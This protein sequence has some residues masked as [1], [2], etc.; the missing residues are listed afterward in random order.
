MEH[1]TWAPTRK[2][3]RKDFDGARV[4]GI[5][6]TKKWFA[7]AQPTPSPGDDKVYVFA[8]DTK[9]KLWLIDGQTRRQVIGDKDVALVRKFFKPIQDANGR[10]WTTLPDAWIHSHPDVGLLTSASMFSQAG[11]ETVTRIEASLADDQVPES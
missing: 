8:R 6:L 9:N 7:A 11:L 10:A 5:A 3:D 4:R 2:V 1:K